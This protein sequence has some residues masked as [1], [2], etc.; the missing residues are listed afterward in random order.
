MYL[1]KNWSHIQFIPLNIFGSNCDSKF[2]SS[3]KTKFKFYA[4]RCDY[5]Q[6]NLIFMNERILF[7]FY[8]ES[9]LLYSMAL[10]VLLFYKYIQILTWRKC[11]KLMVI[12]IQMWLFDNIV[13]QMLVLLTSLNSNFFI[14]YLLKMWEN[15]KNSF[16]LGICYGTFFNLK[17]INSYD[18]SLNPLQSV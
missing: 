13:I 17:K 2:V 16:L 11:G 12:K 7:V 6:L 10:I 1:I 15:Q 4:I 14:V 9:N 3:T 5:T 8:S 18:F